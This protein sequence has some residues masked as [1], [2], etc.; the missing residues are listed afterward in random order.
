MFEYKGT[1]IQMF[2]GTSF[3]DEDVDME[4]EKLFYVAKS[5]FGKSFANQA[6]QALEGA[7]QQIDNATS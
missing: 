3:K 5:K 4:S 2:E 1:Q 7:K 6:E